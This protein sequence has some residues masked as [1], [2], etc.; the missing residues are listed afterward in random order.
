MPLL[1]RTTAVASAAIM[2]LGAGC[3]VTSAETPSP[4]AVKTA[5]STQILTKPNLADELMFVARSKTAQLSL[6]KAGKGTLK[7]AAVPVITWFSDRPKHDAGRSAAVDALRAFGWRKNGDS[8]GASAPNAALTA[9]NLQAAPVMKLLSAS[10]D[11]DG[12]T[13]KV[14]AVSQARDPAP[15]KL[16]LS[17]PEL[18]IDSA[19]ECGFSESDTV[20]VPIAADEIFNPNIPGKNYVVSHLDESGTEVLVTFYR[21]APIYAEPPGDPF[22]D[23]PNYPSVANIPGKQ[24]TFTL[25]KDQPQQT[26]SFLLDTQFSDWMIRANWGEY[27]TFSGVGGWPTGFTLGDL[28]PWC[29]S[30]S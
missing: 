11:G 29:T 20:S 9:D 17:T 23:E 4:A 12:L 21:G 14:A 16:R 8:L 10:R 28:Y 1:P 24:F 13:F 22:H 19:G 18:F 27:V 3:S 25:T 15:R 26:V 6:D 30:G 2:T 5:Q 7:L